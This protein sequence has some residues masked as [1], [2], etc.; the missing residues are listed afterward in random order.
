MPNQVP[1]LMDATERGIDRVWGIDRP[2]WEITDVVGSSRIFKKRDDCL[3]G[4]E[5]RRA[6]RDHLSAPVALSYCL[7]HAP[8]PTEAT[9]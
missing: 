3:V 8:T 6:R 9:R 7:R 1:G 4:S 2:A 5:P